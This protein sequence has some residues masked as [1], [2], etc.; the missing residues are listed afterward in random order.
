MSKQ[1]TKLLA[2]KSPYDIEEELLS[3]AIAKSRQISSS[4]QLAKAH[5]AGVLSSFCH[6]LNG[7]T[8]QRQLSNKRI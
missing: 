3:P 4:S 8:S 2:L 6:R 7:N 5:G 1:K